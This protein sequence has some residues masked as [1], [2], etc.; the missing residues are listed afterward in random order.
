MENKGTIDK[1]IVIDNGSGFIRAGI[2]G[3]LK[4]KSV[5]HSVVGYPK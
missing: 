2:S 5:F 1:A 3:E 4:P